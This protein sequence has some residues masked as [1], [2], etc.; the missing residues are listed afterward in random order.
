MLAAAFAAA[1]GMQV[2]GLLT[3]GRE[4]VT[5]FASN[6]IHQNVAEED[7]GVSFRVAEG[8]RVGGARTN[9]TDA[10][11][12]ARCVR[13]AAD[14]ARVQVED[15]DFPGLVKSPA[16]GD[17]G[18]AD[19][20]E[21]TAGLSAEECAKAVLSAIEKATAAGLEA[22]GALTV[23]AGEAA[24][25]NSLGTSQHHASTSVQ[26]HVVAREGSAEGAWTETA[27][28]WS[29]IDPER[30][31][32][33]AVE[34]AMASR[35]PVAIEP[36]EW[37]VVLEPDAVAD[38]LEML[39]YMGLGALAVLEGRS[40]MSGRLGEKLCSEG[41]TISD[42]GFDPRGA[43]R[44]FDY[45]GVPKKLVVLIEKGVARGPVYDMRTAK[46]AGA[47]VESTGHALPE[48]NTFGPYPLNLKLESGEATLEEMIASTEKGVL[49]SRFHYTNPV[50]PRRTVI[51]GMTRFGTFLV[52]NGKV[53]SAVRSMRF[54]D[55]VIEALSRVEAV[56]KDLRRV[57]DV[58]APALKISSWRFTGATGE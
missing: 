48:P 3:S 17:R 5:R 50:D 43:V 26:L 56:G 2:E 8:G 34:K 46:K 37:T 14:I 29:E 13:R 45:E 36:G 35:D 42:D 28:C 32:E 10:G 19:Y 21:A 12:L 7:V 24:V 22:S 31:A 30:V 49:V 16:A 11:R 1:D 9:G 53:T 4:T 40:F 18:L 55:N 41:I 47:G 57:D 54:T 51:T 39:A 58:L 23:S 33:R 38:M 20:D 44:T 15:A 52:E 25:A 27:G 6:R